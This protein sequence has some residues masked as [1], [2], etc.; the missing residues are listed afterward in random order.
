MSK[1]KPIPK[2]F[3]GAFKAGHRASAREFIDET[4]SWQ[5][6][7][8][9]EKTNY[10]D[11]E[12]I[13]ALDYIAKFNNEFHKNV[14]KKNDNKSLHNTKSLRREC[15]SRENARNRDIMSIG[16][17]SFSIESRLMEKEI[18]TDSSLNKTRDL[19][20]HEDVINELIDYS[21]KEEN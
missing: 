17:Y 6:L 2:R 13:A 7:K 3:L 12:A 20:G 1:R 10:T 14:I 16:S 18:S 9:I 5:L 21:K 15:Y 8:Q 11:K 19:Y 4:L